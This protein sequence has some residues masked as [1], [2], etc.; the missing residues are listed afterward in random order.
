MDETDRLILYNKVE[1]VR[2]GRVSKASKRTH[3][4]TRKVPVQEKVAILKKKRIKELLVLK[5]HLVRVYSQFKAF[6][7]AREEAEQHENIVTVQLYWSENRKLA[8]SGE[9]KGAYY[10]EKHMSLHPMYVWSLQGTIQ[11][12]QWVIL[13]IIQ[14]Q[15]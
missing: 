2:A 4:V 8:Q 1:V 15:Q 13:P 3:K 7:A 9:E 12:R 6:K 5:D 14:H 11:K 10:Y